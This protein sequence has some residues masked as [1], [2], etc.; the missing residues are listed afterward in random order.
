MPIRRDIAPRAIDLPCKPSTQLDLESDWVAYWAS[1]LNVPVVFHRKL[2]ELAFVLQAIYEN[3]HLHPGRPRTRVWMWPGTAAQLFRGARYGDHRT[4]LAL[5]EMQANGWTSTG[6]HASTIDEAFKPDLVERDR[7]DRN[8][9]LRYVD[10][11]AIPD[12]LNEYDFA[13]QFAHSSI[14]EQS[15]AAW[16]SSK[17]H[18]KTLRAGGLSVHTTEF[19]FMN[20]GETIDDWPTVLFQ[21]KHFVELSEKLRMQGHDVAPLDFD[22]GEK[23]L[24]KFIDIP[25]FI[26]DWNQE[27]RDIW[28]KRYEH[29]KVS[30]DGFAV[31]CFGL[32]VRKAA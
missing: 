14:L 31:T 9:S 10:M 18:L 20:E 4:D 7:F 12:D 17:I 15:P 25:P 30:V 24:D 13:G 26:H 23:P 3:G 6:Q 29:L 19:N 5:E 22:I 21:R 11:N 2:W 28:G 32:I 16:H 27:I 1:E 8:V